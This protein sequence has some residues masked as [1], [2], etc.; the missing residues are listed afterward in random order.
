LIRSTPDHLSRRTDWHEANGKVA[1]GLRRAQAV[2]GADAFASP[3]AKEDQPKWS[4]RVDVALGGG[5]GVSARCTKKPFE[6]ALP[7]TQGNAP[8]WMANFLY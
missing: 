4:K 5:S 7:K 8:F 6:R 1:E 3:G 2:Q